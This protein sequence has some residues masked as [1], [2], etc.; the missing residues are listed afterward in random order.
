MPMRPLL[1][2]TVMYVLKRGF[3][4]GMAGFVYSVLISY[5]EFLIILKTRELLTKQSTP[6]SSFESPA[7]KDSSKDTSAEK[8]A[9][10]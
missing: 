3:L 4:D 7:E 5:Y 8:A 9:V 6:G 2:F 10:K 1:K